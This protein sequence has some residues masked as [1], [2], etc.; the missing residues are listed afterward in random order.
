[1]AHAMQSVSESPVLRSHA[2]LAFKYGRYEYQI[3]RQGES[4]LYQVSDGQEKMVEPILYSFGQGHAGQTYILRHNDKIYESRVSF[5][6]EI[7]NLDWTIGYAQNLPKTLEEAVGRAISADEAR[8]CFSC[9]GTAAVE[10]NQLALEKVVPGVGCEACHGPG[11][12]HVFEV[13]VG[14]EETTI[15]TGTDD[16]IFNPKSLDPDTLSQEFCGACHRSASTVEEMPEH[17]AMNNVRFQPYRIFTS[18]G[19]D[20]NDPHLACT[21]CHDPHQDLQRDEAKY[22]AKCTVCHEPAREGTV[23]SPG[24]SLNT[25]TETES[26]GSRKAQGFAAKSCPVSRELCVSCHM[27][28]ISVAS[29]HFKFTDHR[30]RIVRKGQPYPY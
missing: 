21:A 12:L 11:E 2:S 17:A 15:E 20:P 13:T 14:S 23:S 30:I 28:K 27:P 22:D 16:Y 29:A 6:T 10:G 9:H 19:H 1:M 7:D 26:P 4:S 25:V 3:I 24:K 8:S 5:Y 18:K